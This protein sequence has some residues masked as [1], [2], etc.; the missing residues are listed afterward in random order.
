[1][2]ND[3]IEEASVK[4]FKSEPRAHLGASTIGE[5]CA[6]KLWFDFRKCDIPEFNGRMLRLF[7]RGHLEEERVFELLQAAGIHVDSHDVDGRQY[8]FKDL[9]GHFAGSCD[10]IVKTASEDEMLLEIKT[11]NDRSFAKLRQS[12]VA[13]ANFKHYVQ[14]QVYMGYLDLRMAL[15]FAVNKN[16]D[17][18]YTEMV[19][20]NEECFNKA[21]GIAKKVIVSETPLPVK[22]KRD[23]E[24][25]KYCDYKDVCFGKKP[26]RKCCRT[27][28]HSKPTKNESWGC[29]KIGDIIEENTITFFCDKYEQ[30]TEYT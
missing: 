18:V 13:I 24:T 20:F 15:Y 3:L 10:G 2:I 5:G 1:M 22:L 23:S 9:H 30:I 25:C 4:L 7:N 14:M 16:T 17:E 12:G 28:V 26:Y 27:C 21:R 19:A 11:H 29:R 8:G 6:R